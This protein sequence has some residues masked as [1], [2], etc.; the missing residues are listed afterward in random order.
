MSGTACGAFVR[1]C[2]VLLLT[3][4]MLAAV[5]AES[6]RPAAHQGHGKQP[7]V[8]DLSELPAAYQVE[9]VTYCDGGFRVATRDGDSTD[10]Q[11][12]NLLFKVDSGP[13]GPDPQTPV[14]VPT[15]PR[16]ERAFVVVARP[17][18]LREALRSGC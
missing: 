1:P 3:G 13:H 10:F 5:V 4:L 15:E 11:D 18:D 2:R 6:D 7:K 16:R 17:A 12:F 14:L 8:V 9:A